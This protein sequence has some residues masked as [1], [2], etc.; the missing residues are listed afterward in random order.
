MSSEACSNPCEWKKARSAT[1]TPP[2]I[3]PHGAACGR[4]HERTLR[5]ARTRLV[6]RTGMSTQSEAGERGPIASPSSNCRLCEERGGGDGDGGGGGGGSGGG[7]GGGGDSMVTSGAEDGS[8]AIRGGTGG[9]GTGI[10]GLGTAVRLSSAAVFRTRSGVPRVWSWE[11]SSAVTA[12]TDSSIVCQR[13]HRPLKP[14]PAALR[15][16]MARFI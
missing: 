8:V 5:S 7:K 14:F 1:A 15:A 3:G 16:F 6:L 9:D 4:P 13:H 10:T 11:C 2:S 12:S